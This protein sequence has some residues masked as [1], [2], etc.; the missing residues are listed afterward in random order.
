MLAAALAKLAVPRVEL[1]QGPQTCMRHTQNLNALFV[2]SLRFGKS[3]ARHAHSQASSRR[4][5]PCIVLPQLATART[6]KIAHALHA[7]FEKKFS[8][9]EPELGYC[10]V[11]SYPN[12]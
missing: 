5:K 11:N 7:D 10:G 8:Q 1:Q 3:C 4:P 2:E 12:G 6:N 9:I